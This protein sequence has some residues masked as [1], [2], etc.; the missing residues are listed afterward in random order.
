M[1]PSVVVLVGRYL[2][3][4]KA[5]GP[6]RSIAN[7]VESLGDEI[8]FRIVTCDRDLGDS[9]AYPG[10]VPDRWTPVGKAQVRYTSPERLE[11]LS[12]ARILDEAESAC[13]YLNSF[14]SWEFSILPMFLVMLGWIRPKRVVLAPR[15]EF[16]NGALGLKTWKKRAFLALARLLPIYRSALWHAS[17]TYEEQAIRAVFGEAVE[18]RVALPLSSFQ[19]KICGS[20]RKEPGKLRLISVARM[21]PMKNL[22]GALRMLEGLAGEI[23]F[24]IYGPAEDQD[25][26]SECRAAISRLPHNIRVRLHAAVPHEEVAAL[27]AS[28]HLFY[29][30][31][32]G[33]NYGH[34]ISEALAAGCPV[35]L[36]DQTPWRGLAAKGA[37]WDLPLGSPEKFRAALERAVAMD[38]KEFAAASE[39]ARR[40]ARDFGAAGEQVA[41]SRAIFL[42][43]AA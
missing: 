14:F 17:S 6:I 42:G 28:H 15:G 13:L 36:S 30:P 5:G 21:A 38:E 29:F 1:K 43:A 11:P 37:G 19:E 18:L 24:N 3:G 7:L 20:L 12:M 4:M 2:P 40:F 39:A 32:L 41:R 9:E 27:F 25:Y 23:E 10:I 31:T 33:E 26:L 22:V 34:V 16:S 35:L 8:G